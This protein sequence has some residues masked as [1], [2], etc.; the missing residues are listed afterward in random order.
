MNPTAAVASRSSMNPM[1]WRSRAPDSSQ[2]PTL[3]VQ[4]SFRLFSTVFRP[5]HLAVETDD[6]RALSILQ[7]LQRSTAADTTLLTTFVQHLRSTIHATLTDLCA[8]TPRLINR[9]ANSAAIDLSTTAI[10]S[11]R[12][13]ASCS[14]SQHTVAGVCWAPPPLLAIFVGSPFQTNTEK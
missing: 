5:S 11:P 1:R 4:Q 10:R 3:T 7:D 12:T 9:R 14:T 2:Q 6:S 13:T 8:W